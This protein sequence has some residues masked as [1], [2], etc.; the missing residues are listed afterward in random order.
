MN[1]DGIGAWRSPRQV[2]LGNH[3]PAMDLSRFGGLADILI[4][5]TLLWRPQRTPDANP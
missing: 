4:A 1:Q 3:A 2:I 5:M